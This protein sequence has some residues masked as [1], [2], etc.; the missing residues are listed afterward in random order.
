MTSGQ[1]QDLLRLSVSTWRAEAW[2]QG[3]LKP[4]GNPGARLYIPP[5]D[6]LTGTT[7]VPLGVLS[8]ELHVSYATGPKAGKGA[9]APLCFTLQTRIPVL[10]LSGDQGDRAGLHASRAGVKVEIVEE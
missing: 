8:V 10:S 5:G 7:W 2:T 3:A 9:P 4:H 6:T 1:G